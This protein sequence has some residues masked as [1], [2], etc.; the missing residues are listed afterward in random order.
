MKKYALLAVIMLLLAVAAAPRLAQASTKA[1]ISND[2]KA[3]LENLYATI[4]E[5]KAL[6][7]KAKAVLVFPSILKGGLIIGGQIG[8]G[9]LFKDGKIIGYYRSVAGSYGLQAG[10]QKFGYAM[11]FMN[12]KALQYLK[13]SKGW[14]LGMGP[15]LVIVDK[16]SVA[17]FGK[18]MTTSTLKD[19]IYAFIFSQKGL[20]GGLGLQGSKITKI[21]PD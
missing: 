15:S 8:D 21:H 11:F 9:A 13:K 17:A 20:M 18:S 3:A 6:G 16:E 14:E 7:S 19:D 12:E 1:E 4:P 10:V 5:A 2:A